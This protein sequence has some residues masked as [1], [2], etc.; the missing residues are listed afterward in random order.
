MQAKNRLTSVKGQFPSLGLALFGIWAPDTLN[1]RVVCK[2]DCTSQ[3]AT[4]GVQRGY[5]MAVQ[6][7]SFQDHNSKVNL[8]P[9]IQL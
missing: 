8:N 5:N 9:G 4:P 3:K 2:T 1:L 7:L 6:P